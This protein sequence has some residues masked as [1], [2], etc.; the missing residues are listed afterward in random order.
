MVLQALLQSFGCS[1]GF[2]GLGNVLANCGGFPFAN[3]ANV[4][5]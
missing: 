2:F 3:V 1:V 5:N 4:L